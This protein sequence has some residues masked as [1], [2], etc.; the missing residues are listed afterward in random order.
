MRKIFLMTFALASAAALS[1]HAPD[2]LFA[3]RVHAQASST[4]SANAVVD[5]GAY[6][7]MH[8]RSVGPFRGGRVTAVAGVRTQ[9]NVFYMGAT[10][11]G[12]WKTENYGI[13][14]TP[15]SDGQMETGSIGAIDVSDSNPNII[16]VGT[17]SEAIRSNVILGRGVYKSTDAGKTWQH[18]GLRERRADRPAEDRPEESGHRVRRGRR[19]PLRVDARPRRVSVRRTA[20]RPGRRCCSSTTR[21]ARCRSRSTGRI[22]TRCTP[23]PGAASAARGRSSAA[24]RRPKAASTRPPTA[25]ITGRACGNGLPDDL[26]GK[27]WVDVAQS[28]PQR[29][30]RA[31]RGERAQGRAVPIDRRRRALDAGRTAA[32]RCARGRSTS[33]RCSSNPKNDNDVWVTELGLHHST[34]GGKTFGDRQHAARRQPRRL[35]QPRQ[36]AHVHRDQRRRREHHAG[37]RQELVIAAQS[38]DRRA[39]H[40][41]RRRAVSLQHLRAAAGRRHGRA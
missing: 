6:A 21:R 36:S 7:A 20:G 26:I 31:G 18:V 11:G 16:Y 17:G 9:P 32:S 29:R 5:P 34:D 37:R 33:T 35:V 10:G 38:A 3:A 28:N 22:P 14:W 8:W 27:V 13:T 24:A 39:L 15:I 25:A 4:S 1:S 30:L 2:L 12:V 19:Q 23:A 41:G 40:G